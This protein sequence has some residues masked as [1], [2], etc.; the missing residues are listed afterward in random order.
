MQ[1]AKGRT[2]RQKQRIAIG[3][4][5][6]VFEQ[7]AD[8]AHARGMSFSELVRFYLDIGRAASQKS[9]P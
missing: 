5:E 3:F 7:L 1:R 6:D 4:D 2:S 8:E 9:Q